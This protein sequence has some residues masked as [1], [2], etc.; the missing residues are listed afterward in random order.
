MTIRGL[1]I[2]G[3]AIDATAD[4]RLI[5]VV[6]APGVTSQLSLLDA[7]G[8]VL[9]Q[10]DGVSSGDPDHVIDEHLT[11]G[12]YSLAVRRRAARRIHLDDHAHASRRAVPADPGGTRSHIRHRGGDFTGDGHLD[13]AVSDADSASYRCCW[14]TATAPSSPPER[15]A[16]GIEAWIAIV[17]GDFTGD[18]HLDLAVAN[19]ASDDTVSVLLGNGD[20]TFQPPVTY[21][22]GSM[23]QCSIVA[24]DFTGDGHSTWPSPTAGSNRHV[25][26]LLGNGDGTF[27]PAGNVRG[28]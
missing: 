12:D 15:P 19:D 10:S 3:V 14:A 11:A 9:V 28:R 13:L 1:A 27:Q 5:A 8:H 4:E 7:Q 23:A 22:V 25:S 20:G 26:V 16:R 6:A 18:G 21:A 17:A 2:D 24:G